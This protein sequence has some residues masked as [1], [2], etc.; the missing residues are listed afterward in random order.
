MIYGHP[1]FHALAILH[2]MKAIPDPNHIIEF[3]ALSVPLVPGPKDAHG[4]LGPSVKDSGRATPV[5]RDVVETLKACFHRDPKQRI[6]IPEMLAAPWLND[7]RTDPHGSPSGGVLPRPEPVPSLAEDEAI[8]N[9]HF[10]KQLI[11]YTTKYGREHDPLSE[12]DVERLCDVGVFPSASAP[13]WLTM[14]STQEMLP[15]LIKV[16][17]KL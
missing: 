13:S 8:I 2:K 5:R 7:W 11:R 1:P 12:A 14:P 10:M 3:P 9:P 15:A 4:A 6:T 16:S 17:R